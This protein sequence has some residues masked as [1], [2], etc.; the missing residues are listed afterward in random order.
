MFNLF[1][2]SK[3]PNFRILN[4]F[5]KKDFYFLRNA[6]W[7]SLDEGN[8][9]VTAPQSLEVL[10]LNNWRR[11]IFLTAVGEQT[12]EDYV[13]FIADQYTSDIPDNLDH[14]IIFEL[15]ELEKKKLIVLTRKKQPLSKEFELPGMGG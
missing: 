2:K 13:Y 1:K 11:H 9:L 6:E 10:T 15:L 7:S 4:N 14:V 8:I 12:I 3:Y 5:H